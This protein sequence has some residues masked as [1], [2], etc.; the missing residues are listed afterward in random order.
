MMEITFYT[1]TTAD[2]H[3]FSEISLFIAINDEPII[4]GI[5]RMCWVM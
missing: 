2:M 4:D 1:T 3:M 5:R